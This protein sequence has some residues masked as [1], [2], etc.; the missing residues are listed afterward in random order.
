MTWVWT[1]LKLHGLQPT[2]DYNMTGSGV[3]VA[4]EINGSVLVTQILISCFEGKQQDASYTLYPVSK[5]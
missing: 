1:V 5:Y 2:A 3:V 4:S